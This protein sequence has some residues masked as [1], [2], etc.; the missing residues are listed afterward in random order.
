[1]VIVTGAAGRTGGEVV[2]LLSA[3]GIRVRALVRDAQRI[4]GLNGPVVEVAVADLAR[5]GTLDP[6]FRGG[7]KLFLVSSPDPE[8]ATLHGNAIEAAKRAGIKQIVRLSAYGASPQSPWLLLRVHGDADEH[9]SRSGI[10]FTILRAQSF[11]QNTLFYADSIVAE[12]TIYAAAKDGSVGMIDSRDVAQAAA[13]IL[14]SGGHS[15]RVYDLTGPETLSHAQ[16]AVKLSA[17]LG[18]EIKYVDIPR[19]AAR[20]ALLLRMPEWLVDGYLDV[21]G[22]WGS[23]KFSD[24][25]DAFERVTGK[26]PRG[27]DQFAKDYARAF[28]MQENAEKAVAS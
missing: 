7:D 22:T 15:G 28:G 9:L 8:V 27:F 4:K 18:R 21:V 17:V 12:A 24:L 5:P 13:T 19:E 1:M 25:T 6:A 10:S 11:F 2:R 3:R 23:G 20:E 26:K 14:V 16:L